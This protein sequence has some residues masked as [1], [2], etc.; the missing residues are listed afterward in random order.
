MIS[1]D[2][3]GVDENNS[4]YFT[5]EVPALKPLTEKEYQEKLKGGTR[6]DKEEQSTPADKEQSNGG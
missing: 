4:K 5:W 3:A 6:G 2:N 1:H